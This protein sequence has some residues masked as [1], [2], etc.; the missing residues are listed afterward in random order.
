MEAEEEELQ[1]QHDWLLEC[2]RPLWG[3]C[4]QTERIDYRLK[5]LALEEE[6]ARIPDALR[7]LELVM[8]GEKPRKAARRLHHGWNWY[9]TVLDACRRVLLE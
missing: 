9:C 3:D 5:M 7:W 6:L 8:Q 4:L 1:Q 2:G